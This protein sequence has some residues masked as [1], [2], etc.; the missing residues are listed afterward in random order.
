MIDR[1]MTLEELEEQGERYH[2]TLWQTCRGLR[3]RI[4]EG[5][6]LRDALANMAA[7]R[8]AWRD[9]M[10]HQ[11]VVVGNE[12]YVAAQQATAKLEEDRDDLKAQAEAAFYR[13]T[14]MWP[15]Q[16]YELGLR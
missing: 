1:N 14:G 7:N 15:C 3:I 9:A 6:T 16:L 4:N 13:E 11:A 12:A 10:N 5:L 2:G 8:K